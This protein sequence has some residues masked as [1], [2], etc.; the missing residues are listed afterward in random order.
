MIKAEAVTNFVRSST[1]QV[2]CRSYISRIISKTF[3]CQNNSILSW[4]TSSRKLSY[5]QQTVT[6]FTYPNIK[7]S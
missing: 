6:N 5:T 4:R 7:K 2:K 3:K 1:S